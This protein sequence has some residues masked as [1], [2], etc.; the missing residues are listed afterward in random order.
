MP[1]G[2]GLAV[3]RTPATHVAVL[4]PAP[5]IP[6]QPAASVPGGSDDGSC[7]PLP[8]TRG[9]MVDGALGSSLPPVD[10]SRINQQM[11]YFS[12]CH[13]ALQLMKT[14]NKHKNEKQKAV[15]N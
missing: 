11:E 5:A 9:E 13:S 6:L 4:V 15:Y 14:R 8:P 10:I 3:A 12:V 2:S 7:G 1:W